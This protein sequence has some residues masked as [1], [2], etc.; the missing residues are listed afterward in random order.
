MRTNLRAKTI[1]IVVILIAF[2]YG[3]FGIPKGFSGA[4]LQTAILNRIQLGLDLK[5]GT[6]LILQVMTDEAVAAQAAQDAETI[7]GDLQQNGITG[8][9]VT[10]PEPKQNPGLV[11]IQGAP[12]AHV[13][14]INSVL[15]QQFSQEYTI[16]QNGNTSW[17]LQM[18]PTVETQMKQ[19]AVTQSI[20]VIRQRVDALGVTSPVVAPY[21]L[22]SDQILVE[23]PGV[24]DPARVRNVIQSTAKLEFHLVEGGPWPDQQSALQAIGGS[25]PYDSEL[26][27]SVIGAS[28][29]GSPAAWYEVT[30]VPVVGGTDIRDAQPGTNP[31]TNEPQVN[32]YLTTSA[33]D[34]FGR[35]TTANKGKP[36][37]IVLDNRLQEVATINDTIRDQ[38]TISGGGISMQEA[39]D[40]SLM[41]R[42]GALPASIKYLQESTIGPSLGMD[43]IH[44]GVMA[45]IFGM[46][47]VLIFM[48]IYYKGAG[49]NADLAL[50]LNLVILLGFMGYTHS[51]LTL[52]G[53]AGVILTVGM[54]VDS[55]V[56]IFER[57][58]EELRAGKAP[59]A[60]VDQGFAHAWTTILDT[61]VTT[62]V[63]AAI[64]FIFG[65][66]AVRGFAVTLTFGLLANLFTA[67]FV[68]RVIFEA[69]L[70]RKQRGEAISI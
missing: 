60:A 41:L 24:D 52:P 27:Q 42:T 9:Q 20:E 68:S 16:S 30:K 17:T 13:Q 50:I 46:S 5:G 65:T 6:H 32:F 55:N 69:N 35:F 67:V 12:A 62:V 57:I 11:T 70:N 43:S 14:D 21:N 49:I 45:S 28:G 33:G 1:L 26:V 61:H 64:L 7:Q 25:V 53:I 44:A 66:G 63:S 40:L 58:R 36:L 15:Q 18:K 54:G 51:V 59:S 3:I 37:G 23:L 56:L 2:V 10:N 19:K 39:K 47:A 38:G 48:L 4:A 8:E 22:G 34:K 31:N 29:P